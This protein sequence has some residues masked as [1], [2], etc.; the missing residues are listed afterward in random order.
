[1]KIKPVILSSLLLLATLPALASDYQTF[2]EEMMTPYGFYKKSLALTSKQENRDKA[3]AEVEKL[4]QSWKPFAERYADDAPDRLTTIADFGD[5]IRRPL[6]VAK[7]ALNTLKAGEVWQA[8]M[9][10]EEIRYTLWQMRTEAGIVTLNDKIND[11]HEAM[12]IVLDGIEEAETAEQ[13][14]H[15]GS[16]YG[17]WLRIKW[18]EV[19]RMADTASDQIAFNAAVQQGEDAIAEL[20]PLLRRGEKEAAK[21]VGGKIKKAYKVIFFLPECS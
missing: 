15:V 12:E 2:A 19:A 16:R 7:E 18:L 3:I 5:R 11:F 1:M 9:Q 14:Q 4:I 10:L 6:A 20:L 13:L 17:A 8:H 21:K